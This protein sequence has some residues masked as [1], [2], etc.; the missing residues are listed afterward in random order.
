METFNQKLYNYLTEIE[1]YKHAKEIEAKMPEIDKKLRDEFWNAVVFS[2]IKDIQANEKYNDYIVDKVNDMNSYSQI[3]IFKENWKH[4]TI[5]FEA[6]GEFGSSSETIYYAIQINM[7]FY[8]F[9]KIKGIL[10]A[11]NTDLPHL[12]EEEKRWICWEYVSDDFKNIGSL[13]K[14]IPHNRQN[15]ANELEQLKYHC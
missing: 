2:K 8:D 3:R 13:L 10:H 15:L 1:N 14:I 12:A 9:N 11:E 4:L 5:C 6:K 7:D